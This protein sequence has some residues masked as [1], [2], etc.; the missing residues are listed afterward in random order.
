MAA[1]RRAGEDS[2]LVW[3]PQLL[4]GLQ[5]RLNVPAA[6]EMCSI[7]TTSEPPAASNAIV[8]LTKECTC[9]RGPDIVCGE[10]PYDRT[11]EKVRH[12]CAELD[13]AHRET[14]EIQASLV[15]VAKRAWR[16]SHTWMMRSGCS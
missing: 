14:S 13:A 2:W 16:S 10:V 8:R 11:C 4:D 6:C 15:S 5:E 3:L 12:G 1:I 7:L 9:C